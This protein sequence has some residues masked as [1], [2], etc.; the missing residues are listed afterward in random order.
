MTRVGD[1]FIVCLKEIPDIME[2]DLLLRPYFGPSGHCSVGEGVRI[3]DEFAC[4]IVIKAGKV[5]TITREVSTK[6]SGR[7]GRAGGWV[8][9]RVSVFDEDVINE[10]LKAGSVREVFPG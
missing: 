8:W 4:G 5:R 6:H 3:R 7:W 1:G 9:R 2:G 10:F